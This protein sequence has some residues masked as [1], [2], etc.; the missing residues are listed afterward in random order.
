MTFYLKFVCMCGATHLTAASQ[1]RTSLNTHPRA[2]ALSLHFRDNRRTS[3]PTPVPHLTASNAPRPLSL[4]AAEASS[5]KDCE[6][7]V[8]SQWPTV[9][10][11]RLILGS[12]L[13]NELYACLRSLA[14]CLSARPLSH[15]TLISG[16]HSALTNNA[17]AHV[18]Y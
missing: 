18:D 11:R 6:H 16:M 13:R 1:R 12:S 8:A 10:R 2:S 17:R 5:P 4:A 3:T 7:E 9:S 14:S 15:I